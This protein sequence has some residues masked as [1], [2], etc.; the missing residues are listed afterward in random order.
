[1]LNKKGQLFTEVRNFSLLDNTL[2]QVSEK[3]Y[4]K[5]N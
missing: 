3:S 1:M 4:Q 5:F 2:I